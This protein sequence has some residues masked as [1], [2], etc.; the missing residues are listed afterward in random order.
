MFIAGTVW[1]LLNFWFQHIIT[2]AGSELKY[3]VFARVLF[4]AAQGFHFPSLASISSKN[5]NS[6]DRGFF[7]SATTAGSAFGVLTTGTIG[8]LL[9]ETLGW[10]SVFY[11]TGKV[12]LLSST[13]LS[14]F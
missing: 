10:S 5:L 12:T 7:F 6:K 9:N 4:G 1:A 8:S 3:V 14:Y 2:W 13:Y 11:F